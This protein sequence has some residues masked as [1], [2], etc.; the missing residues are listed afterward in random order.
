MDVLVAR[1]NVAAIWKINRP[2]QMDEDQVGE[3]SFVIVFELATVHGGVKERPSSTEELV[4][5]RQLPHLHTTVPPA[6]DTG[7]PTSSVRAWSRL[8]A[9]TFGH[10]P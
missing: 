2:L 9:P 3:R 4:V 7:L 6:S 10:F 1:E 5:P 8:S